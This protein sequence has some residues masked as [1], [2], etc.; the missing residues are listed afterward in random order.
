MMD[1]SDGLAKDLSRLCRESE[2]GAAVVL[3][4][5]PVAPG[6]LDLARVLPEVDPRDLA[7]SGG[8]DF[9]LLATLP[10]AAIEGAAKRLRDGFGTALTEVGEIRDQAGLVAVEDDGTERTLEPRGWDHFAS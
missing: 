7:L 6:L 10:A 3:A 5:V 4:D 9:E 8:E 2:V 1:I